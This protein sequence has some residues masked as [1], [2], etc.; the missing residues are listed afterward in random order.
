[1]RKVLVFAGC[2]FFLFSTVSSVFGVGET[3]LVI[4]YAGD[5]KII[6]AG[7]AKA[8]P[9]QPGMVLREG[10]RIIT[11]EESYIEIVFDRS[12]QNLVKIK[13]NTEVVIKLDDAGRIDLIDG[14]VYT[15]LRDI[16][17]GQTF[18][19]RTPGAVCGARG[20]GWYTG[21]KGK[22]TDIVSFQDNVFVYG[23]NKDGSVKEEIFWIKE[24]Y[25]RKVKK[26]GRPG[27]M[28]RVSEE[29]LARMRREVGL[30]SGKTL[31]DVNNIEKSTNVRESQI[32]SIIEKRNEERLDNLRSKR[33]KSDTRG[34]RVGGR[35]LVKGP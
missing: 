12:R 2:L 35:K 9:C 28:I 5:V 3:V 31:R 22:I 27:D 13:A 30:G 34:G 24:G 16:K 20:T 26:F 25:E 10:T 33:D 15:L 4:S 18:R 8:I 14:E 19:V 23:V 6:P 32:S 21:V 1:M 11:G 7:A 29:R 17:E